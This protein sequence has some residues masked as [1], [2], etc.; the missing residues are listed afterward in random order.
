VGIAYRTSNRGET[1]SLPI[2]KGAGIP[3]ECP[4]E[5][6]VSAPDRPWEAS[7]GLQYGPGF[8][9]HDDPAAGDPARI[10]EVEPVEE[11]ARSLSAE[12]SI[13][14]VVDPLELFGPGAAYF[15]R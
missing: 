8:S 11:F 2:G 12:R 9:L 3:A 10:L 14:G 6:L 15:E 4:H 5:R 1:L 7:T 13:D